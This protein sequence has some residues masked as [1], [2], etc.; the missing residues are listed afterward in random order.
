MTNQGPL[1]LA[2]ISKVSG[3]KTP[4]AEE[5][6]KSNII[7]FLKREYTLHFKGNI[8]DAGLANMQLISK[9]KK[10]SRVSLFVINIVGKYAWVFHLKGKRGITI[11]NAFQK[12]LIESGDKQ[13]KLWQTKVV[14]FT[15]N[16]YNHGFKIMLQKYIQ[17]IVKKNLLLLKKFIGTL[18]NKIQKYISFQYQETCILIDQNK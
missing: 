4:L 7:K 13:N 14:N 12:S 15:I 16:Q 2:H 6:H 3:C 17:H 8:Q 11:T 5:L 18:K 9:H 1:Y 10:K